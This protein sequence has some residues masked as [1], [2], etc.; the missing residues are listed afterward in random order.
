MIAHS[1]LWAIV[2]FLINAGVSF[3]TGFQLPTGA[4][5][6][7]LILAVYTIVFFLALKYT[8]N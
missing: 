2:T 6:V 3:V 4:L 7:A 8:R 5:E 1:L